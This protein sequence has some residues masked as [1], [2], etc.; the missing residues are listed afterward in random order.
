MRLPSVAGATVLHAAAAAVT[1]VPNPVRV[2]SASSA[3]FQRLRARAL[4]AR[5]ARAESAPS[6]DGAHSLL[7]STV[8]V[9]GRT[10]I[11]H[12]ARSRWSLLTLCLSPR[13]LEEERALLAAGQP[14]LLALLARPSAPSSPQPT[15]LQLRSDL[16]DR[17]SSTRTPSQYLAEFACHRPSAALRADVDT[18]VLDGVADP[19]NLGAIVRSAHAF[20]AQQVIV[21]APSAR[22]F[23]Q[24]AIAASAGSMGW[25]QVARWEDGG[26]EVMRRGRR[27]GSGRTV[28]LVA[29]GGASPASVRASLPA[30]CAVW[31]LVGNESRGLSAALLSECDALCTIPVQPEVESLNASVAAAIA[32]WELLGKAQPPQ[33]HAAHL[34]HG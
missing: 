10:L 4:A 3:E 15:L 28:G 30:D 8:L 18:V 22:P 29:A 16:L 7:P 26:E 14:S 25:M 21:R 5:K 19:A 13:T 6:G 11:D 2:A 32:C 33:P 23:T 27:E 17:L 34:D 9:E 1:V 31:L 12:L 20:G 24:K